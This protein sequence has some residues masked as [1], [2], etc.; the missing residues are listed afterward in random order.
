M[1]IKKVEFK[2]IYI[3][4]A[5]ANNEWP[6]GNAFRSDLPLSNQTLTLVERR[7]AAEKFKSHFNLQFPIYLDDP[8][9][10]AFENYFHPWPLRW[11]ILENNKCIYF[12][13]SKKGGLFDIEEFKNNVHTLLQ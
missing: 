11:Y 2:F 3:D 10:H 12:G 8:Q 5:H 13:K 9:T 1:P 6:I 4:E 7:I